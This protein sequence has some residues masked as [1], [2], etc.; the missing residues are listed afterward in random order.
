[1]TLFHIAADVIREAA[2]RRYLAAVFGLIA[3]AQIVLALALDLDVVEG[4]IVAS[5]FF[6]NTVGGGNGSSAGAV[7]AEDH[8]RPMFRFLSTA[9]YHLGMLFGVVATG[10]IAVKSLSPGR[11]ELLLSLPVRRWQAL[12][13]IFIG[14]GG[15]ALAGT[16]FAVGGFAAVLFWKAEYVTAAPLWGALMAVLGFLVVYSA[17]LLATS[18]VRSAA[19]A[20]GVGVVVYLLSMVADERE[21]VRSWFTAGWGRELAGWL[22]A[23]LPRL[24]T[25]GKVG[26]DLAVG[27]PL[28]V[29]MLAPAALAAVAFG[30]ACLVGAVLQIERKDY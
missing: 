16:V 7:A 24:R 11:V 26:R 17:M 10:D 12:L 13:G 18:T 28:D 25:L 2:G 5:K 6:G 15:I 29:E 20:S 27:E 3:F 22:I 14:V 19:L 4:A 1:M 30:A 21:E 9:V 8:L 23:P